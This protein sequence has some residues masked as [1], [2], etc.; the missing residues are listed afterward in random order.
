MHLHSKWTTSRYPVRKYYSYFMDTK[1]IQVFHSIENPLTFLDCVIQ[2]V[3]HTRSSYA[4][5]FL[6]L[7]LQGIQ[8]YNK[9]IIFYSKLRKNC[10]SVVPC[11][12]KLLNRSSAR[13]FWCRRSRSLGKIH[14]NYKNN[15]NIYKY[16]PLS[17]ECAIKLRIMN[18]A[19]TNH[20]L[21]IHKKD[22][23]ACRAAKN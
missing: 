5:P 2:P 18:S 17:D 3:P 11:K 21:T 20:C 9:D 10:H 15:I 19:L 13:L 4:Y 1:Y 14:K 12:L 6:L 16:H 7:L 23:C 22:M 8:L